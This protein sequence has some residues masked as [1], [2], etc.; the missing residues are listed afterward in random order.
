[1]GG[2]HCKYNFH[3][4]VY[5]KSYLTDLLSRAGSSKL[6]VWAQK[7]AGFYSFD[8]WAINQYQIAENNYDISLNNERIK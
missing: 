7:N 3:Y 1:M 2:Q 8:D 5:N 4:S 6:R